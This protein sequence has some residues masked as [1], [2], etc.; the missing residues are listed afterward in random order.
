MGLFLVA[1]FL[2]G[3]ILVSVLLTMWGLLKKSWKAFVWSGAAI[4]IPSIILGTQRGLFS[5]FFL[6]PLI[7]LGAAYLTYKGKNG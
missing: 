3:L 5:L 4:I 1:V 7:A 6:L 2:W